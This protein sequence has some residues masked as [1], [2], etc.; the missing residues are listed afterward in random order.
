MA[1]NSSC[2]SENH[3]MHMCALKAKEYDKTNA[4]EFKKLTANPQYKCGNCGAQ[5]HAS[6][7]L[8]NPVKL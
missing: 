5:A 2:K 3:K 8:C 1:N 4:A 7:N 6:D